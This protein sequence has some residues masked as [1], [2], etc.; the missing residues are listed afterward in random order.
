MP[1]A[2]D[3]STRS[4]AC[5]A[6]ILI[7][8]GYTQ[9]HTCLVSRMCCSRGLVVLHQRDQ[10]WNALGLPAHA[11]LVDGQ[12]PDQYVQRVIN[13]DQQPGSW[14]WWCSGKLPDRAVMGGARPLR[15]PRR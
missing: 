8:L 4:S 6:A 14:P 13:C 3:L 10:E 2:M 12:R 7:S 11:H 1:M 15:K 9:R 5:A